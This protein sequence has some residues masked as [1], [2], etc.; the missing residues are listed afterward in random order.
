MKYVYLGS[1]VLSSLLYAE[2]SVYDLGRIEVIETKDISQ[3]KTTQ[4][5]DSEAIDET[6]SKNVV[7]ALSSLPGVSVHKVGRK[8]ET[9]VRIR[10][11]TSEFIPIY[12]D[13][14][15]VYT[16]Y[17]RG[18]DLSRY[19]ISDVSEISVSKGYVSPM[20]GPNT[21][22]GAINIIT[23][24]PVKEFEGEISSGV[25]S[26]SGHEEHLTL[27]TNQGKYYGLLS[28]SNYERDY[29]NL[30]KDFKAAGYENGGKRDNSDSQDKKLNLKLGYTPNDTD[31]YSINYIIQRAEKGNPEYASDYDQGDEGYKKGFRTRTWRWPAWDKTSYYFISKT[32][33]GEN[34]LKTRFYY[35]KF[36]N[37]LVA[38]SNETYTTESFTSEYDDH[39]IGGNVEMN[40][41]INDAQNLKTSIMQK[42]DYHKGIDSQYVGYDVDVEGRTQ[43]LG[44]EYAL[45]VNNRLKWVLGAAYDKNEVLKA[46]G[47]II[48]KKVAT[49]IENY[50][51][52]STD[53]ISPQ[54]ALY[55]QYTDD[56]MF[57][58]S[59]G[60]RTNMPSLNQRYSSSFG[61]MTP[62][63]NLD[64]EKSMNYEIGVE[65]ILNQEHSIKTA[66]FYSRTKDYIDQVT[67]ADNTD[68]NQNIGEAEQKGIDLSIDSYWSDSFSSNIAYG[69]VKPKLLESADEAVKYIIRI[70][71]H[72]ISARLNYKP[73][74]KLK[75]I[76]SVRYESERYVNN[77]DSNKTTK[78]FVLV[79]LKVAY[80]V[81]K[82]LEFTT[83]V[84]NITDKY[85]YYTE[86]QPESGRNYYANLKY[87]F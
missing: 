42:N 62:N 8:N 28:L 7:E 34:T 59:V 48:T 84:N 17:D 22:G 77:E 74:N 25:F 39:S 46:E 5:V 19:T 23:K 80:D 72:T 35:D 13:G 81:M 10:G 51:K 82:N 31:E 69:Y 65:H 60:Q 27:G 36:Y 56:T 44:L 14:I 26:G 61:D 70:P 9:D 49:G 64:S 78:D 43:T 3:N 4:I 87:T 11:F 12:V 76:P 6:N 45:Q 16:P 63:P 75:I 73:I 50:D 83:G 29:F 47:R 85:Y 1:M 18:T 86:G 37:K 66:V 53:A 20:F 55:F 52:Y 24:K 33:L 32:A 2:S 71:E 58:A 67:L 21:L 38:Y 41:K 79:D 40:F 68:Q 57:Y 30:S 54:T 15:P